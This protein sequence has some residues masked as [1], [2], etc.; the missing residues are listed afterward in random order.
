MAMYAAIG[1]LASVL[2]NRGL[3]VFHDGL[4][5]TIA[6]MRSGELPRK[7]VATTSFALAWGF[8]WAFG[9][10][11]SVGFVVPLVYMIFMLSDWIGVSIDAD[12]RQSWYRTR[13]GL[14][15]VGLSFGAG[16]AYGAVTAL[17]LHYLALWMDDLP[18]P[19]AVPVQIFTEPALGAFFLFA[20]LTAAYHFGVKRSLPSLLAGSLAWFV[21][22]GADLGQ[23]AAWAFVAA[24]AV[25][26]VQLV[27]EIRTKQD[28]VDEAVAAWMLEDDG[29]DDDEGEDDFM[30]DR[31]RHI[32]SGIVP[33]V[34]LAGLLGAAYNWGFMA[35]DPISGQLYALGLA[36]PAALV[37]LAWAF[38]FMPMKLT[39][40]AVTGCMATSTFL[41]A[42]LAVLMPNPWVAAIAIG[43]L[44]VAEV[45]A[46]LPVVR[47]LERFP[48]IREVADVMRTAIFHVMEIAFLIGGALAAAHF[49]GTFG[50]AVVIGAWFLNSRANAPVM[51]MSVGPVAALIVGVVANVL[52]V[53]GV[54]L[55]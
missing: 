55:A 14:R 49:A 47:M 22:A 3:S 21:A 31:V 43:A 11:F 27:Q 10:P 2:A 53:L 42:A 7:E 32:R 25:L 28:E 45:L 35:K 36:I 37:Y 8:F 5:P 38:A 23:P 12:H 46:I 16:A 29:D 50:A 20:V 6:S 40:A 15:G 19:M 1:G 48:S 54:T 9:I 17:V 26:L 34:V 33:I 39:T 13:R 52:H 4:R 24:A 44:R 51:P 18:V 30:V 41:D